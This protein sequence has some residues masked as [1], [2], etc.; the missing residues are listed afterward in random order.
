MGAMGKIPAEF[1]RAVRWSMWLLAGVLFGVVLGFV[2]GF[3]KPR[4]KE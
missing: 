3:T 2:F 1:P 4:V